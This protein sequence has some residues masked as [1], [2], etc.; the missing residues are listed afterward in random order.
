MAA[1]WMNG[2]GSLG[3][4]KKLQLSFGPTSPIFYSEGNE[5]LCRGSKYL[6]GPFVHLVR[7]EYGNVVRAVEPGILAFD[8][9]EACVF[10]V[11]DLPV[12]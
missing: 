1:V 11:A 3:E 6:C 2:Y 12:H 9:F 10:V 7:S 8:Y 4:I 5:L